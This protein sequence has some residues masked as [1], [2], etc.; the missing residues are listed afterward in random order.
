MTTRR[1][2]AILAA[3]VVGFSSMVERDEKGTLKDAKTTQRDL[4]EPRLREQR[5]RH[6]MRIPHQACTAFFGALATLAA[7]PG[8]PVI[9]RHRC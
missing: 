7:S 9:D 1:L 2:A 6:V 4:V 8:V 3:D 5:S